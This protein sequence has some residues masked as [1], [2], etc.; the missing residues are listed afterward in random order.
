MAQAQLALNEACEPPYAYSAQLV[1]AGSFAVLFPAVSFAAWSL[2]TLCRSRTDMFG[3]HACLAQLAY[4]CSHLY[5]H[6]FVDMGVTA[7]TAFWNPILVLHF[8]HQAGT[9]GALY[10]NSHIKGLVVG[11]G[12]V[13][14][15]WFATG[16]IYPSVWAYLAIV[17]VFRTPMGWPILASSVYTLAATGLE[18]KMCDTVKMRAVGGDDRGFPYHILADAGQAIS[19]LLQCLYLLRRSADAA[20]GSKKVL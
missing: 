17:F 11:F 10:L 20:S 6:A 2:Y 15:A 12:V 9:L 8:A 4:H 16:M 18:V 1:N 19:V 5:I 13:Y 7:N 3:Q 14:T